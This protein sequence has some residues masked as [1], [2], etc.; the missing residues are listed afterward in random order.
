MSSISSLI[1]SQGIGDLY[2]IYAL[3]ERDGLEFNLAFIPEEFD[4]VPDELFD[5]AYMRKLYDMAYEMGRSGYPWHKVPPGF[6]Q[7]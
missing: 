4:A 7:D 5:P 1:R 2:R 3:A 6:D